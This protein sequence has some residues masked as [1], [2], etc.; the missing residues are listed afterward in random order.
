MRTPVG[1]REPAL[2]VAQRVLRE[3][4]A[5]RDRDRLALVS[6]TAGA[7]SPLS[8]FRLNFLSIDPAFNAGSYWSG[9]QTTTV[10]L[11]DVSDRSEPTVVQNVEI[12]GLVVASRA[13]DGQLR[14]VL[15]NNFA[16][17][18]PIASPV[19]TEQLLSPSIRLKLNITPG[20]PVDL[21]FAPQTDVISTGM[22]SLAIDVVRIGYEYPKQEQEYVY[23][24]RD[25]YLHRI[26]QLVNALP[27]LRVL[28]VDGDLIEEKSLVTA[29]SIYRPESFLQG[30]LTTIATIDMFIIQFLWVSVGSELFNRP[31]EPV[32]KP[33]LTFQ[34]S[35]EC[36]NVIL[37]HYNHKK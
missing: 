18:A 1:E 6:T 16:L 13:V 20:V 4:V 14:L 3:F 9:P 15:S 37:H 25:Q 34:H 11:L 17:P 2:A 7:S 35:A 12:D 29:E 28:S 32:Q 21:D 22:A 23:E 10:T 8:P 19:V 24:T 26:D 30:Q 33:I 36:W 5:G 31:N 27:S